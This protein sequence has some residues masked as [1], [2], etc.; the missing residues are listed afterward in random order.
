MKRI[1]LLLE[2]FAA[3]ISAINLAFSL[4]E[5]SRA[6][7][8][9]MCCKEDVD[10]VRKSSLDRL[11]AHAKSLSTTMNTPLD[12]REVAER[13]PADA[14][15]EVARKED[16]NLIVLGV[17][18]SQ[19]PKQL[20]GPINRDV[21]RKGKTPTLLVVSPLEEFGD[22]YERALR[23]ILVPVEH[24]S[25][26]IAALRLAAA[27]TAVSAARDTE[28]IAFNTIILPA[29]V[30]MTAT[31]LPEIRRGRE[32]FQ[33]SIDKFMH[34]TGTR[35]TVRQVPARTPD[36]AII[37]VANEEEV[38]LIILSGRRR[39]GTLATLV[40]SFRIATEARAA[41]VFVYAP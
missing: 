39:P 41:V 18:K 33:Q 26:D 30:P 10:A 7:V 31:D 29:L 35:L 11:V 32:K 4:A 16:I 2:G 22:R 24:M 19:L 28:L 40:S 17:A 20:L 34:E 6:G 25:E 1:L 36:E 8:V 12:V 9:V 15:R 21:V 3:E 5:P 23:K 27:L 38:D 13:H 14:V 37:E